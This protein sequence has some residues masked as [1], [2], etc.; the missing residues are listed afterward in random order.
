MARELLFVL[1]LHTNIS[2]LVGTPYGVTR[3]S[4]V[5]Y[6]RIKDTTNHD[7]N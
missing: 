7:T 6:R 5:S 1:R 4:G 2:R 3:R